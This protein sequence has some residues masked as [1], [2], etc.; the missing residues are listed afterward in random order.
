[1]EGGAWG[2]V[3][4]S[5]KCQAHGGKTNLNTLPHNF[6]CMLNV[7]ELSEQLVTLGGAGGYR[8]TMWVAPI[9]QLVAQYNAGEKMCRD[10]RISCFSTPYNGKN[11]KICAG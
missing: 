5:S 1:M 4:R 2:L 7:C 3:G 8:L 6:L 10:L 9:W 11:G